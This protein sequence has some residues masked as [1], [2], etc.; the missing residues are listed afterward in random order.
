MKADLEKI[1]SEA[2]QKVDLKSEASIQ[3]AADSI[4]SNGI[5]AGSKVIIVDDP[6]YPSGTTGKVTGES[7]KGS[8]FVDVE[9]INGT[10]IPCQVSLLY[11]AA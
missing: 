4:M 2:V 8:G 11:P 5:K 9:L 3:E 1:I 7:K 6:T 10:V